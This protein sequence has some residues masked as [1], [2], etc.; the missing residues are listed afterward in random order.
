MKTLK[1]NNSNNKT[2]KVKHNF[3]IKKISDVDKKILKELDKHQNECWE[4]SN[5]V[6]RFNADWVKRSNRK[7]YIIYLQ[8]HENKIIFSNIIEIKSFEKEKYVY[9]RGTCVSPSEQNKGYYKNSLEV[10]R[11]YFKKMGIDKIKLEASLDQINKIDHATRLKI[12]HKVGFQIDPVIIKDNIALKTLIKLKSGEFVTI[13]SFK[14]NSYKVESVDK[15]EIKQINIDD[16]DSCYSS[17]TEQYY[18]PMMMNM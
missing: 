18:C 5:L 11:K 13:L 8:N 7:F 14:D 12:F 16:I 6:S 1:Q 4:K 15:K 3:I 2:R 17:E 10:V 9:L